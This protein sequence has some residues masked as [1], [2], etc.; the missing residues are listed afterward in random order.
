MVEKGI[1]KKYTVWIDTFLK[2]EETKTRNKERVIM[3][4]YDNK[5]TSKANT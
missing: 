5:N 4:A 2:R 1:E 3:T